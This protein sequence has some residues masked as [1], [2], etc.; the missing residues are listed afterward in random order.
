[1]ADVNSTL[2]ERGKTHGDFRVQAATTQAIKNAYEQSPNW[3]HMSDVQREA[4]DMIAGKIGRILCGNPDEPD[5]YHDIAGYATLAEKFTAEQPALL[6]GV[7]PASF[8]IRPFR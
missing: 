6:Y 8:E 4:L 2:A 1:M 3:P 5:H 7:S